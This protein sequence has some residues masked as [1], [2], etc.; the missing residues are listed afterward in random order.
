MGTMDLQGGQ[1]GQQIRNTSF[2]PTYG[3]IDGAASVSILPNI[4]GWAETIEEKQ[5]FK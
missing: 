1:A 4:L 3:L 2:F 5:S